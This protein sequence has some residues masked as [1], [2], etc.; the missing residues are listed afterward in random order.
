MYLENVFLTLDMFWETFI[1]ILYFCFYNYFETVL[2]NVSI[3]TKQVIQIT[4]YKILIKFFW[5]KE[6]T[7]LQ[8][9]PNTLNKTKFLLLGVIEKVYI[10]NFR[11]L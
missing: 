6:Q 1:P 11:S 7:T 4:R 2:A 3:S 5:L 8:P 9:S 10:T